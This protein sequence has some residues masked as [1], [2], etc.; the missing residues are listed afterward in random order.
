[1]S[2]V[3]TKNISRSTK[4]S[5]SLVMKYMSFLSGGYITTQKQLLIIIT[6]IIA[7]NIMYVLFMHNNSEESN[8][9]NTENY[10]EHQQDQHLRIN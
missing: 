3:K 1:M 8:L 10:Q 7:L 2:L 6:C 4:P 5:Q 9:I